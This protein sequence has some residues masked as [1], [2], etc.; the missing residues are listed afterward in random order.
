M[1]V[2]KLVKKLQEMPQHYK[3]AVTSSDEENTHSPDVVDVS[4]ELSGYVF[5]VYDAKEA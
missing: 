1:T 3:V 4:V 5:I 2:A